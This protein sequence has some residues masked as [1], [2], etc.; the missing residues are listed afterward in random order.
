MVLNPS[1]TISF[2]PMALCSAAVSR[3][4]FVFVTF[5]IRSEALTICSVVLALQFSLRRSGG[6]W[7]LGTSTATGAML[8]SA[9]Q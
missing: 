6:F 1:S 3:F 2:F 9:I 8:L 4:Y 5:P 7:M